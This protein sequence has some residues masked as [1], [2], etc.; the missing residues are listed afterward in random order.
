[1]AA[2]ALLEAICA[3]PDSDEARLVY[4]DW[5]T[6][7]DE[8]IG[9]LIAVQCRL[10]AANEGERRKLVRRENQ[11]LK[12]IARGWG[13]S[14]KFTK[15]ELEYTERISY[16]VY[17]DDEKLR[18]RF[19]RG[20]IDHV[21]A[22]SLVLES[23][24]AWLLDAAPVLSS[25]RI[26]QFRGAG[27]PSE[28]LM[29]LVGKLRPLRALALTPGNG[30]AVRAIATASHFSQLRELS[31]ERGS[32]QDSVS[33]EVDSLANCSTL[34]SLETLD[35]YKYGLET[36]DVRSLAGGRFSLR[37]LL[38]NRS[39]IG[40][41][42]ARELASS[43]AFRQLEELGLYENGLEADGAAALANS[44]HLGCLRSLDLRSNRIRSAGAAALGQA[45]GL[46]SLR[47]LVLVGNTLDA[48]AIAGLLGPGLPN[49]TELN[50]QHTRIDDDAVDA[51]LAATDTCR[52]LAALNLRSNKLTDRSAQ[53]LAACA[54]LSG[55]S[56]LNL[57]GNRAITEEGA[58]ALS[59][60]AHLA[61]AAIHVGGK[62][63]TR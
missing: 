57:N 34:G 60:S 32:A 40:P 37:R 51:L 11:L 45:T 35:L 30:L 18:C 46:P 23:R 43:E 36:N 52:R 28:E 49:L 3:D 9:E 5:L 22:H 13:D 1:M 62:R 14:W 7:Q 39:E 63:L 29:E 38:L 50:L 27:G 19:A 59:R 17:S 4:G 24:F 21:D 55:L 6:E 42:G 12:L 58:A 31:L 47:T 26:R 44:A 56:V 10:A 25:L 61:D 48:E 20:F 2:A 15:G 33:Q 16:R 54:D 53:R 8:P 41:D